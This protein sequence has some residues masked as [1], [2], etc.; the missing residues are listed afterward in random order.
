MLTKI[1]EFYFK[2]YYRFELDLSGV[3]DAAYRSQ[4]ARQ[5][6]DGCEFRILT[7]EDAD[8][9]IKGETS[10]QIRQSKLARLADTEH[11]KCFAIIDLEK[12]MLAY[13]CWTN[14]LKEYYHREFEKV[15]TH[16]GSLV[17]FETD[18]CSPT[19]RG[20]GLHS[21]CMLERVLYAK[22]QGFRKAVINIHIRNT[23]ALRTVEKFG[24]KKTLR[25]PLAYRKGTITYTLNRILKRNNQS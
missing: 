13:S 24:F 9:L 15:F 12:N 14:S 10:E 3:E 21:Y 25:L 17:L 6:P 19:H 23:P 20:M 16:D 22:R 18:F 2:S 4:F 11:R 1:F 5:L 8:L 7:H